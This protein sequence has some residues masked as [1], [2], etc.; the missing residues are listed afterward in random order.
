L[1][2]F[3]AGDRKRGRESIGG[4]EES[5]VPFSSNSYPINSVKLDEQRLAG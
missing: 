5:G 3:I 1:T 2:D 4:V